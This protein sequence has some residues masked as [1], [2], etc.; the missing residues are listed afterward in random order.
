MYRL[1][2]TVAKILQSLPERKRDGS[3]VLDSSWAE[4]LYGDNSTLR[5]GALNVQAEFLPEVAKQLQE[6][7]DEVVNALKEIRNYIKFS[8]DSL[9]V[10]EVTF[11]VQ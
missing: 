8:S 7:P 10:F 2:V 9:P 4:L 6:S 11:S 1:Q 5:A 3:T